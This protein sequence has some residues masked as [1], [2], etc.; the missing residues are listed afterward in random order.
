MV[1]WIL[2]TSTT[3]VAMQHSFRQHQ[4]YIDISKQDYTSSSESNYLYVRA[5]VLSPRLAAQALL[6]KDYD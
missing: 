4:Q 3:P 2:H 5:H 1:K 6:S